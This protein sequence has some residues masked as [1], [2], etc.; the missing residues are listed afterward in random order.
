[1]TRNMVSEHLHLKTGEF[2]KENGRMVNNM[3]VVNIRK[4]K[5]FVKV[6]GKMVFVSNG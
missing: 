3:V 5:L 1:M 4:K 6:F 2:I